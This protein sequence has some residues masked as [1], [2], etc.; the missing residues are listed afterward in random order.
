MEIHLKFKKNNQ[1]RFIE[2]ILKISA[3]NIDAIATKVGTSPR[4]FRDWRREKYTMPKKAVVRLSKLY[5][6]KIPEEIKTLEERWKMY[7][8]RNGKIGGDA[9]KKI[10]GNPGTK[11]G[12]IKGGRRALEILRERGIIPLT[13]VFKK[14]KISKKLAEFVGIMLGDGGITHLHIAIT[15]NRVADSDYIKYVQNLCYELFGEKPKI[16]PRK[17][18]LADTIYFNGINLVEY[19]KKIGLKVGNKVKQQ[20]DVPDWI[21]KDKTYSLLCCRGLMDTDGCIA[22]HRY[23]VNKKRYHY[24][25]LIFTNCSVP[26]ALFVKNTLQTVGLHPKV[27]NNL[28]KMRV[29]LYNSQE[30]QD[31]LRIVGS[32]NQRLLK[33]QESDSDGQR[34]RFA[35]PCPARD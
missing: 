19:L 11:E 9:F 15:L 3:L 29:W 24:K 8:S 30:V 33:F 32:S 6:V 7:K 25:K 20:V 14:P 23:Y 12:R 35:K 16:M 4:N 31:Y 17:E 18:C 13:K 10:Y 34:E 26:L 22:I 21:K 28:G 1:R 27:I 2:S 5:K